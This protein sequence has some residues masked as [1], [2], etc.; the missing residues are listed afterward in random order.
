M[1]SPWPSSPTVTS[2]LFPPLTI[3]LLFTLHMEIFPPWGHFLYVKC[4]FTRFFAQ[5]LPPWYS[6]QSKCHLLREA[7]L[8]LLILSNSPVTDYHVTQLI[9]IIEF[10][11]TY[12]FLICL[13]S[14]FIPLKISIQG[15][16]QTNQWYKGNKEE[17]EFRTAWKRI[18][19]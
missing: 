9:F 17:K 8:W 10:T 13:L 7:C 6:D 15:Q 2:L 12:H 18:T 11:F 14:I 19:Q 1:L 3:F 16:R 5:P 4:S